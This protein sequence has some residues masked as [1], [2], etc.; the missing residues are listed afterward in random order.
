MVDT[1]DN[2]KPLT[3]DLTDIGKGKKNWDDRVLNRDSILNRESYLTDRVE[4]SIDEQ[5]S[6]IKS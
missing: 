3:Y 2:F 1:G 4:L 6:L 5:I